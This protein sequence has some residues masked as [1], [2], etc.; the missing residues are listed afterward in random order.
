MAEDEDWLLPVHQIEI[1]QRIAEFIKDVKRNFR[2]IKVVED[3]RMWNMAREDRV[4]AIERFR[5]NKE[6]QGQESR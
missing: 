2:D 4:K 1:S 5:A 3:R 6:E